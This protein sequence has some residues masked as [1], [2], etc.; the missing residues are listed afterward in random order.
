[1]TAS[2]GKIRG[3][4]LLPEVANYPKDK[5]EIVAPVRLKEALNVGDGDPLVLEFVN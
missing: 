5:I 4:V 1:L 2:N 3:A